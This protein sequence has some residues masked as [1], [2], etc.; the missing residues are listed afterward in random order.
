MNYVGLAQTR[1]KLI[2]F[3]FYVS[4]SRGLDPIHQVPIGSISKTN[5]VYVYNKVHMKHCYMF[6]KDNTT[7]FDMG[8]SLMMVL[9]T[10]AKH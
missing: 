10:D 3:L 8:M 6:S 2:F 4:Y 7:H 9:A 5:N 1:P